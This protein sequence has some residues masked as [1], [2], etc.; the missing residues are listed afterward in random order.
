[1]AGVDAQLRV[2]RDYERAQVE[3]GAV[4]VRDPALIHG[5]QGLERLEVDI[6]GHG[7]D[8]HAQSRVVHALDVFRRAEELHGAALGAVGFETFKN[9]LRIVQ[10][11]G[12][13]HQLDGAV[14]DYARRV[15]ALALVV[16]H[17]EH[18]V[19]ENLSESQLVAGRLF[20]G[21]CRPGDFDLVHWFYLLPSKY[22]PLS[23]RVAACLRPC[24]HIL[25]KLQERILTKF[26]IYVK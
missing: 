13:G 18:V 26:I 10:H 21:G 1:M 20:L 8:A 12:A 2:R 25:C 3:A 17:E 24:Y 14:G 11:V 16:V 4:L 7:R 19:R 15:P 5:H 22:L 23:L 6:L 9:L